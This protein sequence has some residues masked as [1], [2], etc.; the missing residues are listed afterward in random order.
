MTTEFLTLRGLRLHNLRGV[1]VQFPLGQ[2]TVVSG[3]SGAG[4]TSL[5][6]DALYAEAQRRYLQSFSVYTRQFL[7]RFDQ[8]DADEIGDL[9]PAVAFDRRP[10]QAGPRA[11]L[12][13]VAEIFDY[14]RLIFARAGV[15]HCLKC[16]QPVRPQRTS[17]VLEHI[18]TLATGTRFLLG[19]PAELDE[20]SLLE[21][22]FVRV[23]SDGQVLRLGQDALPPGKTLV[24]VDRLEVGKLDELR[25]SEAAETAFARGQDRLAI[26]VENV[27]TSFD[28]RR[29][30]PRCELPYPPLEPRLFDVGDPAG[31]CP[32]C[33]GTGAVGKIPAVCPACHGLRWN[34]AARTVRYRGQSIADLAQTRLDQLRF[35]DE[36]PELTQI[37]EQIRLRLAFLIDVGVGNLSL[38]RAWETLS[39][40]EQQRVRLTRLFAAPLHGALYVFEEPSA[41]LD[42]DS[43][44]RIWRQLEKLRDA[45]NTLVVIEHRP[46]WIAAADWVV[47]LG[48]GAGEEGGRVVYQ[49]PPSGLAD[50]KESV[51]ATFLGDEE[52]EPH[53][54]RKPN[55]LLYLHDGERAYEFPLGVLCVVAGPSGSGKTT[56]VRRKLY[57][58]LAQRLGKKSAETTT[59]TLQTTARLE[60][61][62]L[63]DQEPLART[64]RSNPATYLKIFD[65]IRAVFA[66]TS[67]ARLR[68]L[69]AGAFSFNQ[70]GGR[71]EACQGQ[72]TLSVDMQF[73]ADVAMTCPECLGSR[74]Q[75]NI[76]AVKVRGLSIAEVLD[77]TVREAFRFF[78][79]QRALERRLK[80]LLD[81]GLEYLRLG[82]PLETLS[83]GEAQRLKLAA[84]LAV[85][86]KAGC[87]FLLLKPTIGL[88]PQDVV[89]L[90]NC[91]ERLLEMGHSLI[92][93][94][95]SPMVLARADRVIEAN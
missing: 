89:Q 72:G 14:L 61:V 11:T 5:V 7:E 58:A 9:P 52:T 83:G 47:D 59:C 10:L 12:G 80:W 26:V 75:A 31:A 6:F 91:L 87:L 67:E 77:L 22:G 84:H 66:E 23:W 93:V 86:R 69:D 76:L 68:N 29:V 25:L 62:V 56:L 48:P 71:C 54:P 74:F 15:M 41:G 81:V 60:D 4:K 40:G 32:T 65:D 17:D 85:S 16:G 51:T 53:T 88:H 64:A 37:A 20:K 44:Q 79:A 55:G 82:Q 36:P 13:S 39:S 46:G 43:A 78:R 92:V 90:L 63:M 34:D 50:V 49:G 18:R 1:D 28:R 57:P 24:I 19:F 3:V 94:E 33:H 70:P 21:E 38:G 30:C 42:P 27:V 2:L 45:G 95:S 73:L 8:P 35:E